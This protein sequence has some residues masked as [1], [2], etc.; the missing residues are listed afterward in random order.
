V[1]VVR[2]SVGYGNKPT[3][4]ESGSIAKRSVGDFI[5]IDTE[6]LKAGV[7]TIKKELPE[8]VATK[9][10]DKRQEDPV[11]IRNKE[12]P[13]LVDAEVLKHKSV[14]VGISYVI[15]QAELK[16]FGTWDPQE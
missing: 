13:V 6:S 14:Q 10:E 8:G 9:M 3:T 5:D 15:Q 4:E 16:D 1:R 11:K 2:S 7:L 12:S